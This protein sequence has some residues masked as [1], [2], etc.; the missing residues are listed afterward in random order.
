MTSLI[1]WRFG[2]PYPSLVFLWLAVVPLTGAA[3]VEPPAAVSPESAVAAVVGIL[4]AN[5]LAALVAT[6]PIARQQALARSWNEL[7]GN[8]PPFFTKMINAR[9]KPFLEPEATDRLATDWA[10]Q[11]TEI[12][13]K[14]LAQRLR[15]LA[16]GRTDAEPPVATPTAD[17]DQGAG[18]GPSPTPADGDR[19]AG[20]GPP[21]DHIPRPGPGREVLAAL[22]S[23][24]LAKGIEQEQTTALQ[25]LLGAT[26]N[27]V[28]ILRPEDPALAKALA[29]AITDAITALGVKGVEELAALDF[30]TT[31]IRG[32]TVLAALKRAAKA[33]GLDPDAML[34]SVRVEAVRPVAGE[35][36][37]RIVVLTFTAFGALRR[38]PL[39]LAFREG[40]WQMVADSP[41]IAWLRPHFG[42]PFAFM[43]LGPDSPPDGG[44]PPGG[45]MRRGNRVA[46]P[47][48]A[49]QLTSPAP[50]SDGAGF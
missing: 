18:N 8:Q 2:I 41:L 16:E 47:A 17:S 22:L 1:A 19:G 45:G 38:F 10:K 34:D 44:D 24:T 25:D 46:T 48:D 23:A 20:N 43:L 9:M 13:V 35:P 50:A 11:L 37:S 26:A 29:A 28:T 32:G 49:S 30:P 6:L 33:L 7:W 14:A 39:K 21:R 15:I 5:D 12:D 42:P 31:L 3:A 4:R 27:W 40:V 36:Q